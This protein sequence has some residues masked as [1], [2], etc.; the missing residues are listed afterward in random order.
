MEIHPAANV[1]PLLSGAA[2]EALKA[3]IRENGQQMPLSLWMGK[4][5]DGRNRLRACQELGLA[6]KTQELTVLPGHSPIMYV[7]S[8]NLHRRHLT[9]SQL[10]MVGARAREHFDAE[11]KVRQSRRGAVHDLRGDARDLAGRAIGVSGKTID[12][13]SKV[14][15]K[16]VPELV[17]AC[18]SGKLA[19]SRAARFADLP[20][21]EQRRLVSLG[22]LSGSPSALRNALL[23]PRIAPAARRSPGA[24][25]DQL[26][27][28]VRSVHDLLTG[29]L[30]SAKALI[31]CGDFDP[32]VILCAVRQ[33]E[34]V[35]ATITRWTREAR[36]YLSEDAAAAPAE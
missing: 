24:N 9:P 36:G 5:L 29:N 35:A 7:L 25:F 18:D 23:P 27:N 33:L 19:V 12:Y 1:V 11:A 30:E 32:T 28:R 10:A 8:V 22:K 34:L 17:T 21:E 3:D 16:G 6:P 14:L 15:N 2:Y 31:E 13:A 4:V 20:G 26:V